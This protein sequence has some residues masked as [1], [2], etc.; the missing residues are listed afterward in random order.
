MY[1]KFASER[2]A[3]RKRCADLGGHIGVHHGV[4]DGAERL[5]QKVET[6][7]FGVLADEAQNVH[8]GGGHRDPPRTA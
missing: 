4:Q 5:A 6:A 8:G 2:R 3:R 7:L 1:R